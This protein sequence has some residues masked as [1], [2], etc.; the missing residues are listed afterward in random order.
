MV[1]KHLLASGLLSRKIVKIFAYMD[2]AVG[3]IEIAF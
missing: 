3:F 2:C 1:I